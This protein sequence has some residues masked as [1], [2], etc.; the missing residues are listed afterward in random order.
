MPVSA[1]AIA[2]TLLKRPLDDLYLLGK[3][4]FGAELA[5]WNN[6]AR[7]KQLAQKVLTFDKIRTI[8]QKNKDVRIND[9]YYP[10]K[11]ISPPACRNPSIV[12]PSF[13]KHKIT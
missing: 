11:S 5:K 7:R 12:W 3:E 1:A 6:E 8:W 13:S 9:I 2:T 10:P 4:K